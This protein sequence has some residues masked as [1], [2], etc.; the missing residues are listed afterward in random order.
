MF[1]M[2]NLKKTLDTRK[3]AKQESSS[4]RNSL[5][6]DK[7]LSR[8]SMTEGDKAPAAGLKTIYTMWF[9]ANSK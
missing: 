5:G 7:A 1:G 6:M 9:Y 2:G 4:I 3:N 8:V